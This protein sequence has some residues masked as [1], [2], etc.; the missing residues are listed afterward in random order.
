MSMHQIKQISE[1][2]IVKE[3]SKVNANSS[4]QYSYF[5]LKKNGYSTVAA[6]EV[7][8]KKLKIPLK[9]F[10]TTKNHTRIA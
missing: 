8:S 10:V 2:F 9:N 5:L 1:D 6:L 3:I 4:G 7:L